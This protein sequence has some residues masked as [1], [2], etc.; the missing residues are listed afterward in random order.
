MRSLTSILEAPPRLKI[1]DVGA[2]SLGEDKDPYADLLKSVPCEVIGFEPV[3][4]ECARLNQA[5]RTGCRYLPHAIGDGTPQIFRECNFP[6]TSSLLE[7]DT[8]LLGMF[9]DL[10]EVTQVVKRTPVPTVRLDDLAELRGAD[11][12]KLDLQGGELMALKGAERLLAELLVVHTEVEFLQMYLD[13]PLFG[14]ID[15]HLRERGL[16]I[17][18]LSSLRGATFKVP[19]VDVELSASVNQSMWGEAVYV[20]DF[21]RLDALAP[22]A[23][24]KLALILHDNYGSTDLAALALSAHDRRTGGALGDAYLELLFEQ[25]GSGASA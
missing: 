13:Q 22:E 1:I 2:M 5:A 15:A 20:R 10:G 3:A 24:L 25:S 9:H 19:G 16:L 21:R 12:L 8:A 11:F 17:H 7:P 4:Q 14:D 6:M 18:K 23:L